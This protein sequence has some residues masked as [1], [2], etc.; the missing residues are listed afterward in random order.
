MGDI[1]T[2]P[3]EIHLPFVV[4][5]VRRKK[6]NKKRKENLVNKERRSINITFVG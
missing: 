4:G 3:Q 2:S 1:Q 6:E 5:W